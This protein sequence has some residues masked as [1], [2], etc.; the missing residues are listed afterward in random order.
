MPEMIGFCGRRFRL[1]RQ[2]RKA[3]VE[4]F[5]HDI[6]IIDMREFRGTP[7]WV[8]GGLRCEGTAHDGCQ[9]GCLLYWKDAW[10]RKSAPAVEGTGPAED[11]E[12]A[13]RR[14]LKLKTGPET[15]FCQSTELVRVTQPLSLKG[16]LRICAADVRSGNVG[17]LAMIGMIVRPVFWK[18]VHKYI[19]PI[20][21]RGPLKQTPLVKV[22][23]GRG[24]TVEVR[25]AEEIRQTLNGKGCNRGL[26]YDHGL[27][28]FC[29][30]RHV[31]RDRLDRLISESTGRMVH[32]EGTVTLE[33]TSC[34]CHMNALGG[35]TRQ[36][37]VYWREAWLRRIETA[38]GE[39]AQGRTTARS[40]TAAD[41][42][43]RPD[44][45]RAP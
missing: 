33:D 28:Q 2:A 9:R 44:G 4:C 26:R 7:V 32:L 3:C 20:H 34:F 38:R 45:N 42:P 1:G 22:G 17:L 29:G 8:I 41:I 37:L 25:S 43:P 21:V 16:R 12:G 10:L 6:K 31:V 24:E 39:V 14:A 36:D 13:L 27:N 40:G 35:C 15:Y 5:S 30:T 11:A 19:V 23:L 18:I